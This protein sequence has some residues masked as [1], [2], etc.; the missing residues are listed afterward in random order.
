M[1]GRT[2]QR[3]NH[4][5][6]AELLQSKAVDS[7]PNVKIIDRIGCILTN[8]RICWVIC[9]SV[10]LG[11]AVYRFSSGRRIRFFLV[12]FQL[13]QTVNHKK[14]LYSIT[15]KDFT[16]SYRQFTKSISLFL[17]EIRSNQQFR[18]WRGPPVILH[19]IS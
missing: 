9:T 4:R 12:K 19:T 18:M 17:P 8:L 11:S 5:W 16:Y 10:V 6:A 7:V 14:H 15:R 1:R 13:H 3:A 2:D